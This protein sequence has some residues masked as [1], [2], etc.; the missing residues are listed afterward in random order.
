MSTA[1]RISTRER[2][3]LSRELVLRGAVELADEGGVEAAHHAQSR[4]HLGVE[5]M[6]LY[7]HVDNKSALL[8][9]AVDVVVG[10][11]MEAV[12]ALAGPSP[13]E[14]LEGG[15]PSADPRRPRPCCCGTNGRP[16]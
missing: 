16:R 13:E 1:S 14:R 11:I 6:S 7:Y 3:P 4:Q 9:G 15:P 8:D 5:A 2:T 12:A 10:E